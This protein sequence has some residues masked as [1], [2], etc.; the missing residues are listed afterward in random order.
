[1]HEEN[2]HKETITKTKATKNKRKQTK[3]KQEIC[4]K[5]INIKKIWQT[6]KPVALGA[7]IVAG[8]MGLAYAQADPITT[9]YSGGTAGTSAHTICGLIGKLGDVFKILRI[10]CFAG[11]AFVI[12]GWAWS[13]I[14]DPGKVKMDEAKGKGIA[15]IVAFIIL[16]GV[17]LFL[18]YLPGITESLCGDAIIQW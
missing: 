5:K 17:G 14:A 6:V 7:L 13:Y 18:S 12:M 2:K 11:A 8:G 3:I 1:M 4:M 9:Y 16:F 15:L 10:L